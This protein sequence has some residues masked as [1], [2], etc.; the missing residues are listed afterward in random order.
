MRFRDLALVGLR[1]LVIWLACSALF[2][3]T[4]LF[5]FAADMLFGGMSSPAGGS[6]P[7]SIKVRCH[8]SDVLTSGINLLLFVINCSLL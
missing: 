7:F 6:C 1:L 5:Y 3:L 4:S 8:F 2:V